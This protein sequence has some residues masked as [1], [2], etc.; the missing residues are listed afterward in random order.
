MYCFICGNKHY[1]YGYRSPKMI[2]KM[3]ADSQDLKSDCLESNTNNETVIQ[4]K[5]TFY[6]FGIQYQC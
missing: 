4:Y 1:S 6:L 5:F 2:S 3:F